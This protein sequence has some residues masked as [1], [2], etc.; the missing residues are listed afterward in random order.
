MWNNKAGATHAIFAATN[1]PLFAGWRV[2]HLHTCI[3]L[4][5]LDT[6]NLRYPKELEK[7]MSE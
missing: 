2:T 6:E 5:K 3:Y 1:S 7:Y 4:S